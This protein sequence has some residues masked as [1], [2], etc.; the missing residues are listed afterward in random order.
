MRWLMARRP[1]GD[2]GTS[3]MELLV[4]MVLMTIFG[5]IFTTSVVMMN[6][7]TNKVQSLTTT[8]TTLSNA[9]TTL[10]RSVRYAAAISSPG[11]ATGTGNWYVEYSTTNTGVQICSQ[12]RLDRTTGQLQRRTWS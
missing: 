11:V 3:M 2:E 12:L 10:D 4:G 5:A 7:S 1:R 9:F 6:R 8:A